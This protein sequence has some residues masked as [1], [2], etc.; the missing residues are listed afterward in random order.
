MMIYA[1]KNYSDVS[2]FDMENWSVKLSKIDNKFDSFTIRFE[3]EEGVGTVLTFYA[4][5]SK[6]ERIF[7]RA[8]HTLRAH[9]EWVEIEKRAKKLEPLRDEKTKEI[10]ER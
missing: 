2:L 7:L 9:N 3:E 6:L 1:A 8:Y 4:D 10:M 5:P